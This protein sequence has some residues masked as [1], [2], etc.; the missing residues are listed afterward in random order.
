MT[1]F[2]R[3]D[4]FCPEN[5]SIE[6]SLERI[7]LYFSANEVDEDKKV[8][9]FLSVIGGKTYSILIRDLLAPVKPL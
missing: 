4:E 3:I 9:I 6:A 8:S 2:S 7:E 5:E 1:S